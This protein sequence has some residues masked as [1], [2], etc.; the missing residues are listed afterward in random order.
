M[1]TSMDVLRREEADTYRRSY[2]DGVIDLFFGFSLI[3]IGACWVW[4][5]PVAALAPLLP[6]AL[7]PVLI[8]ARA[9]LLEPRIGYLRW[10]AQ[11]RT[12]ER[13]Q[14]LGLLALGIGVLVAVAAAAF[15]VAQGGSIETLSLEAALPAL[16]VAI[17][18]VILAIVSG[19]RRLWGYAA[20][21]LSVALVTVLADAGP[22]V[23]LL[24]AG[25]VAA[26]TGAVL[27]TRFIRA[28][29]VRPPQ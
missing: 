12:W 14:L 11:R 7:S 9:R 22:G 17:P 20:V 26:V 10:T 16:L 24:A 19:I 15:V 2:A 18:V 6:A 23:P 8:P 29:P 5:E 28:Y 27:W 1:M 21:L 25:I 13:E 3:W 4:F